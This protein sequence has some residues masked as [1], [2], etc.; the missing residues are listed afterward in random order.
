MPTNNPSSHAGSVEGNTDLSQAAPH[1][2]S[3]V[4]PAPAMSQETGFTGP[5]IKAFLKTDT[6]NHP[7][8]EPIVFRG[9]ELVVPFL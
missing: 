7:P 3:V 4:S 6:E 1:V 2:V 8:K 9:A 5:I